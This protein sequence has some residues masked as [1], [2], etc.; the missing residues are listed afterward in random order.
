MVN[1]R[2]TDT[3]ILKTEKISKETNVKF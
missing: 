3:L 2:F 1:V